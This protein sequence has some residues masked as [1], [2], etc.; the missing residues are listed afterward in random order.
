MHLEPQNMT[1]CRIIFAGVMK[2]RT[3]TSDHPELGWALNP[4][5]RAL[6]KDRKEERD[7]GEKAMYM[8]MEPENGITPP[9]CKAATTQDLQHLRETGSQADMGPPSEPP[10]E[11]DPANI[12]IEDFWPPEL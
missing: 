9:S 2:V 11:I 10:A 7:K 8:T 1:L 3:L 6:T 12:W 4:I 5:R